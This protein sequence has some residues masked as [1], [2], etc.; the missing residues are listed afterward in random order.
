MKVSETHKARAPLRP[1]GRT[2]RKRYKFRLAEQI[3]GD[4]SFREGW[5]LNHNTSYK[6]H[7]FIPST[8]GMVVSLCRRF[9]QYPVWVI[10]EKGTP[11]K[12]QKRCGVCEEFLERRQ[13]IA[14]AKLER[15]LRRT[16]D[17]PV[18][19]FMADPALG[20]RLY[21]CPVCSSVYEGMAPDLFPCSDG[22]EPV[23]VVELAKKDTWTRDK[24]TSNSV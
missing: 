24:R 10:P 3:P 7:W 12:P 19:V 11:E 13:N 9:R 22:H 5:G 14:K 23:L 21:G 17:A 4:P 18:A 1:K 8:A 15:D 16:L 6:S 2:G 20:P